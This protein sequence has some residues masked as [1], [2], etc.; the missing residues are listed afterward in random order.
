[1]ACFLEAWGNESAVADVSDELVNTYFGEL[2]VSLELVFETTDRPANSGAKSTGLN[3]CLA[4]F[5]LG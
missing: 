3:Q 5:K 2:Q 4:F 1:M